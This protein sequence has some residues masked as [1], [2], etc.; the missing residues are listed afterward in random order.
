[1]KILVAGW[2]SFAHGHATAGDLLT[3]DLAC[4]WIKSA[5]RAYDVALAPPFQ[6]GVDLYTVHPN[7]YSH[8]VFVCGPFEQGELEAELLARFNHCRLIGLNLSMQVP[9]EAWNPFDFLIERDST[10]RANPDMAFL[11]HQPL[12]PVVGI[13]LVE[14]YEGAIDHV[15]NA[16]IERLT[17][18][19]EMATVIIDTRLDVNSVGLRSPA[20]I[21]SLMARMDVVVTTRLHGTVLALKNGV[22]AIAIDPVAGGAKIRRQAETIGWPIILNADELTDEALRQAFDYC[23]TEA[24]RIEARKCAG[25]AQKMVED[26]RD[27][28][29]TML[30]EPAEL[31]RRYQARMAMPADNEW[32]LAFKDT[33]VKTSA[34]GVQHKVRKSIRDR[35]IGFLGLVVWWTLPSPIHGWLQTQWQK[36]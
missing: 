25:R 21:E 23:L 18:W 4:Q 34:Y 16:A 17:A 20:E 33:K 30:T 7:D 10:V 9:I 8:V 14:P 24:A 2:F 36:R 6:G 29:T 15:A 19:Q 32:M 35:M 5:G 13:C 27:E 1:M 28:F 3:C 12:A 22:P 26:M 11:S 31:D